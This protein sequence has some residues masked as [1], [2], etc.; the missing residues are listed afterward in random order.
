[1]LLTSLLHYEVS[2]RFTCCPWQQLGLLCLEL[3]PAGS[4]FQQIAHGNC[5]ATIPA[6]TRN[7]ACFDIEEGDMCQAAGGA[8]PGLLY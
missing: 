5:R 3:E 4:H 2:C 1:M 8:S 6:F 7:V